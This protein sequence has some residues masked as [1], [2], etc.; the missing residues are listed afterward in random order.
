M[1]PPRD[2]AAEDRFVADYQDENDQQRIIAIEAAIEAKRPSLAARILTLLDNPITQSDSD[3][4]QVAKRAANLFLHTKSHDD[5][6]AEQL[7]HAWANIRRG[8]V[9]GIKARSRNRNSAKPNP[10]QRGRIKR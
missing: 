8:R 3:A 4:L 7:Y 6:L 9:R 2:H 10:R 1:L 5:V